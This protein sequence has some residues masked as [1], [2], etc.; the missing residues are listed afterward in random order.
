[1]EKIKKLPSS[2]LVRSLLAELE[3]DTGITAEE[4]HGPL[5]RA[6]IAYAR[7]LIIHRLHALGFYNFGISLR[8]GYDHSTI[9]HVLRRDMSVIPW[10][11]QMRVKACKAE[12]IIPPA[13]ADPKPPK[14]PP[15][16]RPSVASG[17]W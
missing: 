1:M 16:M 5:K 9:T 14:A 3:I 13:V 11:Y 6:D 12:K 10:R 2:D 4:I 17:G 8:L 15:P 7:Y